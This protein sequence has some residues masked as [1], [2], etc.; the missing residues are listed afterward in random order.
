M[1]EP[2]KNVLQQLF[3]G[4]SSWK[5][6]FEDL[7]QR[8][9]GLGAVVVLLIT[10]VVAAS[11]YI[12]SNWKDIKERP[13]IEGVIKRFKRRTIDIAP[14]GVLTIAVAHLQDDEGQK[15]EKLLLD[16]LKH[17]DGVE[18]LTVDRIVEWPA[19]GTEQAKKKK[20]EEEA[21]SLLKQTRADVLIWGSVITL[22]GK[23]AMRLYWT[24]IAG[25]FRRQG[26]RKIS[27]RDPC[28]AGSVLE[29]FE[30]D[31]GLAHPI[32]DCR[33]HSRSIRTLRRR[34]ARAFDRAGSRAG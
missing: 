23:S 24:T 26:K 7:R 15:Q 14:A 31:F 16:E 6:S 18:T 2:E 4:I 20:A 5:G 10:A 32:P 3:D 21:R 27:A 1:A 13:G 30:A 28:A 12:W 9:G 34:Q 8:I 17:F 19:S 25:C 33:A 29:R 22:G 11:F